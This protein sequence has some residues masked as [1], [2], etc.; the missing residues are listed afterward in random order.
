MAFYWCGYLFTI[1]FLP[2]ATP[3]QTFIWPY[4]IGKYLH[5]KTKETAHD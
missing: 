2:E 5:N 4:T 1:A 3:F